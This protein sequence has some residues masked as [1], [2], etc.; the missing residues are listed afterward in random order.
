MTMNTRSTNQPSGD[1]LRRM[2]DLED[3]HASVSVGGMAHDLG[4]MHATNPRPV[5]VF[6]QF[7]E[8]ARRKHHLT[9]EALAAKT[10]IDLSEL[11][12]LERDANIQPRPRTVYKL[13]E[14]L[15]CPVGPL[16]EIAGLADPRDTNISTAAL[17]FAARSETTAE[18]TPQENHAF[19]EFVKVIVEASD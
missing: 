3:Q 15:K 16:M 14:F 7:V 6:G 9:V 1:W 13:A 8:F 2:A 17:Q 5:A 18:L 4:M 10:Q 12:A 19:E 11:L